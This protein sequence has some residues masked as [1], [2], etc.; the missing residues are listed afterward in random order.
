M[1]FVTC[2][3]GNTTN[4]YIFTVQVLKQNPVQRNDDLVKYTVS[5]RVF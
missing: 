1:I 5:I 3:Q 2:K 4:N